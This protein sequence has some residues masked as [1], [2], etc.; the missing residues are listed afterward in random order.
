MRMKNRI[1]TIIGG[2]TLALSAVSSARQIEAWAYEK[3][4]QEA[5]LVV[6][7]R[8]VSTVPSIDQWKAAIFDRN[9]FRGL[10][11]TFE[12]ATTL[13][14]QSADSFKM[15]HFQYK[16]KSKP[17]NDGPGFVSFLIEPLSVDTKRSSDT[18]GKGP[19]KLKLIKR[20]SLSSAPEYLL[21]LKRKVDGRFEAVSGQVDPDSSVRALF[22]QG[23]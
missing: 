13:K 10:E 1:L 18:D 11:T 22:K 15:L 5:D 2:L 3:L 12:L 8:A 6:I 9:R 23:I 17:F 19:K 16:K 14:G 4:L 20:E 21:F 7:A